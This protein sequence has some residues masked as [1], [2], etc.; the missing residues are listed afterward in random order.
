MNCKKS[1]WIIHAVVAMLLLF[2]SLSH[3]ALA[4]SKFTVRKWMNLD[5]GTKL[6]VMNAFVESARKDKVILR[7]P[8]EYYVKEI[9]STVSNAYKRNDL[10]RLEESVGIVIHT[11]A[12]M[13]G[14][15]DNGEDKLEHA[16]R[17]M[18]PEYF[19]YFK[20]H[21][22]EKYTRLEESSRSSREGAIQRGVGAD[23]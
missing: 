2:F 4:Q 14:D 16:K 9:D 18:G 5:S 22:P 21:Y 6:G 10:E 1:S 8:A 13:E 23:R 12:A 17:W 15:W 7:L 19:E 20:Q 11:I 3:P